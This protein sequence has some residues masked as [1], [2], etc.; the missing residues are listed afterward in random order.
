MQRLTESD[1]LLPSTSNL[2]RTS[3]NGEGD[4]TGDMLSPEGDVTAVEPSGGIQDQHECQSSNPAEVSTEIAT[5][6]PEKDAGQLLRPTLDQKDGAEKIEAENAETTSPITQ[7]SM[8]GAGSGPDAPRSPLVESHT[9]RKFEA[10]LENRDFHILAQLWR[11]Q[12]QQ[13]ETFNATLAQWRQT[14]PQLIKDIFALGL[15]K[16]E[17]I[18]KN[19]NFEALGQRYGVMS[20]RDVPQR[21]PVQPMRGSN[22][23]RAIEVQRR[24]PTDILPALMSSQFPF[25]D[26]FRDPFFRGSPFQDHF[27]HS[28]LFDRTFPGPQG[29]QQARNIGFQQGSTNIPPRPQTTKVTCDV[30]EIVC[31]QCKEKFNENGGFH[32]WTCKGGDFDVCASC[33]KN[34]IGCLN[35]DHE[36]APWM[37]S[38]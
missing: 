28:L 17:E 5:E 4:A 12:R 21:A 34:N 1:V 26:P 23:G 2:F 11:E 22:P 33:V 7:S 8:R 29:R 6:E 9:G 38:R 16:V 10:L 30:K 3:D 20:T 19:P 37:K 15:I 13:P 36:L 24:D 25:R 31:N 18:W 35:Q 27:G 14:K 32:C